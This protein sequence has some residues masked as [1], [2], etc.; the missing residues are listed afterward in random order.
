MQKV[1][2]LGFVLL[3]FALVGC[4]RST[5]DAPTEEGKSTSTRATSTGSKALTR[6]APPPPSE[7]R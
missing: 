7:D 3:V 5:P 1:L 2:K 6:K 4:S